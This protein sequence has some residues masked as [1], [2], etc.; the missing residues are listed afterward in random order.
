[1]A[2]PPLGAAAPKLLASSA[3]LKVVL[4]QDSYI[5]RRENLEHALTETARQ[6]AGAKSNL[7]I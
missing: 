6:E 7:L 4:R 1:M 2:L 3:V 5:S